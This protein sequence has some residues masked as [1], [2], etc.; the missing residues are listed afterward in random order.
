MMYAAE[1]SRVPLRIRSSSSRAEPPGIE[2]LYG[3]RARCR[4][5]ELP[6]LDPV[7][8]LEQQHPQD[9]RRRVTPA[10]RRSPG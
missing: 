1:Y 6:R 5:Q 4:L 9:G 8:D 2:R 3:D 7:E 10:R